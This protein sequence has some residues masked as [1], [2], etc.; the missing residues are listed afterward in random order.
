MQAVQFKLSDK[1]YIVT[2]YSLLQINNFIIC[3]FRHMQIKKGR[4]NLDAYVVR[5]QAQSLI[6]VIC[7]LATPIRRKR[8]VP[9]TQDVKL[10]SC[11]GVAVSNDGIHHGSPIAMCVYNSKCQSLYNDSNGLLTAKINV[12]CSFFIEL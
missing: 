5:G 6:E 8:S 3:L 1:F 11:Y 9:N 10:L 4:Q 7:P 12:S 2:Q